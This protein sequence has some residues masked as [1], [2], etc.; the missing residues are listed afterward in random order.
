MALI[1]CPEC[2]KE[3]SDRAKVCIHCGAP[4]QEIKQ[5]ISEEEVLEENVESPI[6]TEEKRVHGGS[7][8]KKGLFIVLGII[9]AFILVLVI[10]AVIGGIIMSNYSDEET[11]VAYCAQDLKKRIEDAM[12]NAENFSIVED[13]KVYYFPWF[14]GIEAYEDMTM[15]SENGEEIICFIS[16]NYEVTVDGEY[17]N[18]TIYYHVCFEDGL[19]TFRYVCDVDELYNNMVFLWEK[20]YSTENDVYQAVLA[21]CIKYA[22]ENET[23]VQTVPQKIATSL[24]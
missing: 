22:D 15:Q 16:L 11:A 17:V 18:K 7:K 6:V 8:K 12:P 4:V 24:L 23:Q 9:G 14:Q 20:D 13:A 21:M 19:Y 2:G 10:L 5:D 1:K 3:I